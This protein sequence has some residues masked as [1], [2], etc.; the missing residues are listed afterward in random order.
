MWNQNRNVVAIIT[1]KQRGTVL[2]IFFP[3]QTPSRVA[4]S[5][6]GEEVQGEVREHLKKGYYVV[7]FPSSV[8][9]HSSK[10]HGI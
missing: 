3:K 4:N 6:Y 1:F 2:L 5:S 9:A 10:L 7:R 8:F